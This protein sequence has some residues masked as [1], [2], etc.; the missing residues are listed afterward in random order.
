MKLKFY[1]LLLAVSTAWSLQSCDNDDNDSISVPTELQNAFSSKYPNAANVKWET[2]SGYYVADFYDG[3]EASAWFTQDG[4]WQ[5][6]ETDIPY[7]ALP[8]AV[9][10][11]F[12]SSEY[13]A[14][15]I[16]DVDKLDRENIETVYVI[17]VEKQNQEID[18]YYSTGGVLIK[19]IVD[20]DNDEGNYLPTVK[21]TAEMK[22]FID[23]KY[24]GS[25]V[26]E[27]EI[28]DDNNALRGFTEVD[29]IHENASKEIMFN[30]NGNWY[31]T[32]WEVRILPNHIGTI[33]DQKYAGYR[34]DDADFFDMA[35]GTDYYLIELEKNNAPDVKIKIA[36]DGTEL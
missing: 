13:A 14:W 26:V 2:K 25:Q 4:K 17:E 10:T 5:M 24:P 32:S 29:I 8:Q 3:H 19:S 28:E 22:A 6:T 21:L 16:D 15:K 30:K 33:I 36:E 7:A 35:E 34:I 11:T 18:L 12:E 20:V 27:I 31:S 23:N 1:T 9:K